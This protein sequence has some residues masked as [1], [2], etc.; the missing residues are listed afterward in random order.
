M[1]HI[2]LKNGSITISIKN[3]VRGFLGKIDLARSHLYQV[4]IDYKKY[5]KLNIIIIKSRCN[6]QYYCLKA[7]SLRQP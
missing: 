6:G 3:S 1:T 4:L 7:I 5:I 2:D